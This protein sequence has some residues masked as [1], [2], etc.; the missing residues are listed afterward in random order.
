MMS[1]IGGPAEM[2]SE[3]EAAVKQLFI[4]TGYRAVNNQGHSIIVELDSYEAY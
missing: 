1:F 3:K 2:R 4:E